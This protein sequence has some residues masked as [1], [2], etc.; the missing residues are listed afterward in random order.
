MD[1]LTIDTGAV[2][3]TIDGDKNRVIRFY[4]TDVG[5]AEQ[6]YSLL[7]Q[8]EEK[9]TEVIRREKE[10]RESDATEL[11]RQEEA[12]R[13]QRETFDT[14]RRCIDDLF[15]PG[16]SQTVFGARNS[17]ALFHRFFSGVAPYIAAA[18]KQELARYTAPA[19]EVLE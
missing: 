2:S 19:S 18:R 16:T 9:Q 10:L 15:G 17:I 1:N 7:H 4:P 5:F 3:L 6:Y 8:L 13:L 14:L 12:T 11:Q